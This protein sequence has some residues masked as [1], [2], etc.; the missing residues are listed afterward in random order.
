MTD[1]IHAKPATGGSYIRDKDG[2][3]R[4]AGGQAPAA[5]AVSPATEAPANQTGAQPKK[6]K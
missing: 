4:L 5:E 3:I 6:R 2:S 1:A